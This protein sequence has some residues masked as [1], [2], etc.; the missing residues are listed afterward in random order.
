MSIPLLL[1]QAISI[2]QTAERHLVAETIAVCLA[3]IFPREHRKLTGRTPDN[4]LTNSN[5]LNSTS[6]GR[7][8]CPAESI[9]DEEE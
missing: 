8:D 2:G 7:G 3:G 1:R 5:I 9:G 6:L 4:A